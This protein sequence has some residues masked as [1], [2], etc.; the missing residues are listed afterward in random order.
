[1]IIFLLVLFAA[2][3]TGVAQSVSDPMVDSSGTVTNYQPIT[4]GQRFQWFAISTVGPTSLL[5]AGPISAGWGTLFNRPEEYGPHWEGFGKRYGMRLT[6]V[7]TGNAMEA[8]FGAL[9]HED[10]RY[11]RAAGQP[12]KRRVTHI[13]TSTFIAYNEQGRPMPAYARYIAT[14]GNNFLSNAWRVDS[15]AT[16]KDAA[17]RTVTGFLGRMAGNAFMEFWPDVNQRLFKRKKNP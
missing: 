13:I 6:G 14:P 8:G 17:L 16:A 12:F 15:E 2:V 3:E 4:A 1:L 9:W 10:P 7:S 5:L 11:F